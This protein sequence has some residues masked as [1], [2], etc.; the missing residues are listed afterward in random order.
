MAESTQT[1]DSSNTKQAPPRVSEDTMIAA[2]QQ[3]LDGFN[4]KAAEKLYTL[5]A[6]DAQIEDPVGGDNIVRGKAEIRAFYEGAV[7]MVDRLELDTPIRASYSNA[8]AMAFTIY[9]TI[10][11]ERS[12]IQAIDVMRFNAQGKIVDMKAFHGLS[13]RPSA[14]E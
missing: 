4:E 1:R 12:I 9:M 13:N 14:A 11:G 2:L 8:A 10:D 5:F 3:Y 6:D 7:T